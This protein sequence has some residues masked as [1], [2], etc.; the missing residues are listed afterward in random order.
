MPAIAIGKPDG[1]ELYHQEYFQRSANHATAFMGGYLV[2]TIGSRIYLVNETLE[3][4]EG[5][6]SPWQHRPDF[7]DISTSA[8]IVWLDRPQ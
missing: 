5:E 3:F 4:V 1:R 2:S 6:D 7:E 8:G